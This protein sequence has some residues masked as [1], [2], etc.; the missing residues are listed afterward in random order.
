M[1]FVIFVIDSRSD[2]A[3]PGEGAA[4]DAF[5]DR[6]TA[7]KHLV[8]AAGIADPSR[9]TLIDNRNDLGSSTPGS[10]FSDT[11]HYSGF[12]IIEAASPEQAQKFAN[13]GSMACNRRV[14]LRPF[15]T[16]AATA[17]VEESEDQAVKHMQ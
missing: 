11:E 16:S 7:G 1:R 14:E 17:F 6:L 8:L 3:T 5:N 4:I 9:A 2:T 13:E 12:W 15:L 10:L